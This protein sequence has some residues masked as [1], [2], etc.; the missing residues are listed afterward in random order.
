MLYFRFLLDRYVYKGKSSS[1]ISD[2]MPDVKQGANTTEMDVDVKPSFTT[3]TNTSQ[4]Y[5]YAGHR[6]CTRVVENSL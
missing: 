5:E 3:L 1:G 2:L 4:T 6:T